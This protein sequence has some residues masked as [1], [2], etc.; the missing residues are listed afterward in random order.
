MENAAEALRMAAWVLIF[1]VA[2]SF[3]MNAFTLIKGNIDTIVEDT[4]RQYLTKY[5][6]GN[7]DSSGNLITERTVS[8]EAI[9]PTIYRAFKDTRIKI[10][11]YDRNKN[12]IKLFK[13]YN[14]SK[15][16]NEELNYI[17]SS[18]LN[19]TNDDERQ[20][21]MQRIMLG[22]SEYSKEN[23]FKANKEIEFLNIK[24]YEIL[25]NKKYKEITGIYYTQD[26]DE[27]QSKIPEVEKTEKRII[28]YIEV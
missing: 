24:L 28:K 2:L 15:K 1:V 4:D 22:K 7:K 16:V 10:E 11:F 21:F 19:F 13:K 23:F 17:D 18:E 20:Y 27:V 12:P 3:S 5:V 6:E 25:K 9:V 14:K 8:A 26:L